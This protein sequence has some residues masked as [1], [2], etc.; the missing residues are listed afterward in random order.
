MIA[1]KSS[2]NDDKAIGTNFYEWVNRD[3]LKKTTIPNHMNEFSISHEIE[4]CIATEGNKI[5]ASSGGILSDLRDSCLHGHGKNSVDLLKEHLASVECMK[6]TEDIFQELAYLC[7]R[8]VPG[9]FSMSNYVDKEKI[10]YLFISASVCALHPDLYGDS[11]VMGHYKAF[12]HKLE[13]AFEI[14]GLAKVIKTEK[15]IVQKIDNLSSDNKFKIKGSGLERKFPSIPWA[16]FFE[17]VGLPGWK[18]TMIYYSDPRWFRFLGRTVKAI[19]LQYWK[20]Y[21]ARCY[22]VNSLKYLPTPYSDLHYEF[23]GKQLLGQEAKMPRKN[24]LLSIVYNYMSEDFSKLL[25][26]KAGDPRLVDEIYNFSKEI[27]ESAKRRIETA[28]WML[29]KTRLAAIKKID[30][31]NIQTVRPEIWTTFPHVTL[32]ATNLLKNIILLGERNTQNMIDRIENK[33]TFWEEGIFR[34]NAYYFNY[35]NKIIIPYASCI[36]PFYEKGHKAYNYGSLGSVIGHELCHGF[37]DK[38]K[39]YDENGQK[40][41]WWT[42]KDNIVFNKRSKALVKLYSR[43]KVAGKHVDGIDTLSENIADL[44]GL[45]ISLQALKDDL[46]KMGVVDPACVKEEYRKFFVSFAVSW[47]SKY[48]ERKLKRALTVDAHSPAYLRVNLVVAQF[49]EWYAAFDIDESAP[50]FV[51]G[52]DRIRVF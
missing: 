45:G 12:L 50:M 38:G 40:K 29:Y 30:N 43:Q 39:E 5:I 32:D 41:K 34:V 13:V 4:K 35:M 28:D 46:Q 14:P 1:S 37:D 31:M 26:E 19:P 2:F 49:D 8:G 18:K 7:K 42:R 48:R 33:H 51:K 10:N 3:W 47:R 20:W 16:R 11:G 6:T 27:I 21:L 36:P 23:F 24:L 17:I 22:I 15:F 25:W 9:L 52:E 44:G